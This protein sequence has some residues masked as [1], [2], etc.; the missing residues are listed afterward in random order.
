[1]T[2]WCYHRGRDVFD[3]KV[4]FRCNNACVHCI[5]DPLRREIRRDRSQADLGTAQ[6]SRLIREAVRFGARTIVL[7][8]GEVTI[9]P[10]AEQLLRCASGLGLRVV[11]QTN[12]RALSNRETCARVA[13]AADILFMVALHGACPATHDGVT[14]RAGSFRQTCAAIENL[15]ALGSDVVAKMVLLRQNRTEA[16]STIEL[17]QRLG[18][19][20]ACLVFPHAA[21]FQ[22]RAFAQIVPRYA[23]LKKHVEAAG[24]YALEH[25]FPLSFENFPYCTLPCDR[26]FWQCSCDLRS[27]LASPRPLR[28]HCAHLDWERVRTTMKAKPDSCQRCALDRVCEGPWR[29]YLAAHG[30]EEFRPIGRSVLSGS[31]VAVPVHS[32]AV[33]RARATRQ[34]AHIGATD[35]PP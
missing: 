32:N 21:E 1:M 33:P 26:L 35:D 8:G 29:E 17:A 15:R 2:I 4:G 11:L 18:A 16:V 13:G 6:V 22:A 19:A 10:D 34:A 5:V 30:S 27:T 31:D 24:R 20:R 12:A 25:D 28:V 7:T 23:G 9:R 14:R 3:V